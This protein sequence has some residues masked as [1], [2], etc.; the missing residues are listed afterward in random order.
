MM[1]ILRGNLAGNPETT[2]QRR[3][4]DIVRREIRASIARRESTGYSNAT[5]Q[6]HAVIKPCVTCQATR[7]SVSDTPARSGYKSLPWLHH[8]CPKPEPS[9]ADGDFLAGGVAA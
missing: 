6:N 3:G 9:P 5:H 4:G 8:D 2:H 7:I 1:A